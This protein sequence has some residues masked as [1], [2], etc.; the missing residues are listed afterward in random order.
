MADRDALPCQASNA[1]KQ[2]PQIARVPPSSSRT[3]SAI[4]RKAH[5]ASRL[6][7]ALKRV[8]K[9]DNVSISDH[10]IPG[11]I[12]YTH[13]VVNSSPADGGHITETSIPRQLIIEEPNAGEQIP[14]DTIN[15]E[16]VG[17]LQE[18]VMDTGGV[19]SV[20][21]DAVAKEA[22]KISDEKARSQAAIDLLADFI[23]FIDDMIDI[24][25]ENGAHPSTGLPCC[26]SKNPRLHRCRDC[27][28]PTPL[29]RDCIVAQHRSSPFHAIETWTG[30]HFR[31]S[32]LFDL[33]FK[34]YLMHGG[35]RCPYSKQDA[36][37]DNME[38]VDTN[39]VHFVRIVKCYCPGRLS[40]LLQYTKSKLLPATAKEPRV[41]FTFDLMKDFHVHSHTSKKSAYDYMQAIRRKTNV[42]VSDVTDP[43]PQF[44][45]ATRLWR[46]LTIEKRSGRAFGLDNFVKF[47]PPGSVA[48]PCL[49]C[50]YPG[51]N[52]APNWW[53]EVIEAYIHDK[54][55]EM[56]GNFHL[57]KMSKNCNK[58]D[59]SLW[60]GSSC[61]HQREDIET[62]VS[63]FGADIS[64]KSTCV[65]FNATENQNRMKH[66]GEDI[67]GIFSILCC[68]GVPE[69]LGSV[70][71]QRGERYINVD[72][73]L[74]S[75]LRNLRGLK[76]MVLAYDVACQYNIN[77]HKR[78]SKT[79]PDVLDTLPMVEFLVGKMHLQAH[80][81]ECRYLYSLSYT[82]GVGRLDG[83]ET[84]HFWAE[85]NQA[86]GST[87]QMNT[88]NR[89][90]V[91]NDLMIDWSF[92][93][94]EAAS[95]SL[96]KRLK[97]A[98][99]DWKITSEYFDELTAG[100][101]SI[102]PDV[103]DL[104]ETMSTKPVKNG[105]KVESVFRLCETELPSREEIRQRLMKSSDQYKLELPG[106]TVG[107]IED[108]I[109][110]LNCGI[111]VQVLQRAVLSVATCDS[112]D[113]D[114]LDRKR[115]QLNTKIDKWRE[116]QRKWMP[117]VLQLVDTADEDPTEPE[118]VCLHLPSDFPELQRE[119][120]HLSTLASIEKSLREGQAHDVL[121][122]LRQQL[123]VNAMLQIDMEETV[124]GTRARNRS[125]K[126]INEARRLK[127]HWVSEYDAV[128]RALVSL[129]L[130]EESDLKKLTDKDLYRN[131]TKE[132]H[133]LGTGTKPDGW[134]WTIGKGVGTKVDTKLDEDD[135]V[136][137]FRVR[138]SRDR[139]KEEVQILSEDIRR[140][141]RACVKLQQAWTKIATVKLDA[142][143][144]GAAAYASRTAELYSTL[145]S[146][147]RLNFAEVG[148]SWS[149]SEEYEVTLL[150]TSA[151]PDGAPTST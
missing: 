129:G 139:C 25:I 75:V 103:V 40:R 77:V 73:V 133:E 114:E 127:Q 19:E 35:D 83:E 138:A 51:F 29:C 141:I 144:F 57:C 62:H 30:T 15:N 46:F 130:E 50:P 84:E 67:T 1:P 48:L 20:D 27:F 132:P 74:A 58:K 13:T 94:N 11:V 115:T 33:G 49:P 16:G 22:G 124:W 123:K 108:S 121:E 104:W 76:R 93:K 85:H 54:R 126:A 122:E 71:L 56:D 142:A 140:Y 89:E 61:L 14:R 45:R 120:L 69:P 88:G 105:K 7:K 98:K 118:T 63:K 34:L 28:D 81:E 72:F 5:D 95:V 3:L 59:H 38:V 43:Y 109:S 12:N 53:I 116:E 143:R 90:E 37:G 80:E 60:R 149:S 42:L 82:D 79:A 44:M 128:R 8:R 100:A 91:L 21:A 117:S 151:A 9:H 96:P 111:D 99:D 150:Q 2:L 148:G 135:R 87:K 52:M 101:R 4:K 66:R 10:A 86:A 41:C 131:T 70:D 18:E 65:K 32:S 47:R 137:W 39:G 26:N 125:Q 146:R 23:P 119:E 136:H 17:A 78:F 134:I 92:R 64:E 68:H 147:A 112:P 107:K 113:D 36:P 6:P 24:I 97:K 102:E 31:K 145:A 106:G 110:F 55:A